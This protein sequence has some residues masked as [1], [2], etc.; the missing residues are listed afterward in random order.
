M[1]CLNPFA[2][3][4]REA[5]RLRAQYLSLLQ[6]VLTN[7]I[8]EDPP[9]Q[10]F[11]PHNYDPTVRESGLD[12]PSTAHTMIG[13]KR[14]ANLRELVER[15]LLEKVPGDLLEAGVWRGG[16]CIFM[17]AILKAYGETGRHVWAADSF[18]GLPEPDPAK[19][20]ADAGQVFHRYKELAVSLEQV[21]DNFAKY[22]LLDDQ[23][24][25]LRGWFKDTLPNAPIERLALLRIDG[26]L[27]ESIS[28]A[29]RG[30]YDRVSQG[31]FVVIDDYHAVEPCR[32]ATDEF[33][34]ERG[35]TDAIEEIDG[36]GVF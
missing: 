29:L 31:G 10:P 21:R 14:L 23:V 34:A 17:R 6:E 20:P 28:D 2:R 33:R 27:Y 18:Q 30:L 1:G 7:R 26:D 32:K 9:Q 8:Y 15:V 11:G 3:K 36:V 16:A 25:F 4:D 35:I 12:W 5:Q 22:G 19:Y 24:G 13:V